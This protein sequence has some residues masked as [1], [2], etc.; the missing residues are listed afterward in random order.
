MA[1]TTYTSHNDSLGTSNV[2]GLLFPQQLEVIRKIQPHQMENVF[3]PGLD[4]DIP[5]KG[6]TDPEWYFK[7]SDGVTF[8]IAWRWGQ[9]RLRGR[10]KRGT[11]S[12]HLQLCHPSQSQAV[13]FVNYLVQELG[14]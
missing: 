7:T 8:G 1:E 11:R 9:A 4:I 5:S 3:G 10:G 14:L 12:N 2:T 13:A 6:Y